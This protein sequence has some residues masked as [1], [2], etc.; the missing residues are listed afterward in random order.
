MKASYDISSL[1]KNK[2]K[3][4]AAKIEVHEAHVHHEKIQDDIRSQIYEAYY[5]AQEAHAHIN[6]QNKNIQFTKENERIIQNA[7]FSQTALIETIFC[8]N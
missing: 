6:I 2:H 3:V 7:Y 4:S 8:H 5:K 1:Y